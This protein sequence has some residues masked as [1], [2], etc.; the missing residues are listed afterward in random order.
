[1]RVFYMEYV[2]KNLNKIS[3]KKKYHTE[4]AEKKIK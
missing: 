3:H 2:G 4:L 1:M